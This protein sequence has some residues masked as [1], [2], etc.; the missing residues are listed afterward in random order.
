[1]LC[2]DWNHTLVFPE[3]IREGQGS[4]TVMKNE[5]VH[6]SNY[7]IF[8]IW[9]LCFRKGAGISLCLC[10]VLYLYLTKSRGGMIKNV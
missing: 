9:S 7:G 6:S 8:S 2:G 5:V 10:F 4:D 3:I 1:M